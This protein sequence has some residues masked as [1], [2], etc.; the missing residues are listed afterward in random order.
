MAHCDLAGV[1]H[2]DLDLLTRVSDEDVTWRNAGRGVTFE[3]WEPEHEAT[4][5]STRGKKLEESGLIRRRTGY[6]SGRG[7]V[8]LTVEGKAALRG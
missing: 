7:F 2:L 4:I 8:E 3:L 5:V 6:R 1:T